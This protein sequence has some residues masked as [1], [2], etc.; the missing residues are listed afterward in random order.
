MTQQSSCSTTPALRDGY[1]TTTPNPFAAAQ[2]DVVYARL[3]I[4]GLPVTLRPVV[5]SA[6]AVCLPTPGI[7]VPPG[8]DPLTAEWCTRWHRSDTVP[9]AVDCDQLL[10]GARK[11]LLRL[12]RLLDGLGSA[13]EFDVELT[14]SDIQSTEDG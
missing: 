10:S 6:M 13:H 5:E 3:H 14:V 1:G 9:R 11:E 4:I 12:S 2:A 7:A 8:V